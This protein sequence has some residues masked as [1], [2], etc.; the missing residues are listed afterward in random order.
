[1][2]LGQFHGSGAIAIATDIMKNFG[3][4]SLVGL[5]ASTII[6]STETTLY[7]MSVY[8]SS[9]NIKKTRFVLF[10]ALMADL[11]GITVSIV[12]W[13]IFSKYF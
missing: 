8:T 7:T 6:G 2:Y 13:N 4:D 10:A 9:V 5:I 12:F 1:M 3:V 11:T